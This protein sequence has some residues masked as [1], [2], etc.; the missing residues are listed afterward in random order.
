[1]YQRRADASPLVGAANIFSA[2]ALSNATSLD[3]RCPSSLLSPVDRTPE[4][5]RDGLYSTIRRFLHGREAAYRQHRELNNRTLPTATALL[6]HSA[7][8]LDFSGHLHTWL[9][10]V[11]TLC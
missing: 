11:D 6:H 1:M 3:K 2:R 7:E 8:L 5:A 10:S 4:G 9:G